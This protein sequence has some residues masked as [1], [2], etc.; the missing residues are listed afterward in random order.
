MGDKGAWLFRG[1]SPHRGDRR[2]SQ[3]GPISLVSD[4]VWGTLA[5]AVGR[6]I[7]SWARDL[8]ATL[9]RQRLRGNDASSAE[10]APDSL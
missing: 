1:C 7:G 3:R 2:E 5:A 9:G 8:L 6:R 10:V 4:D